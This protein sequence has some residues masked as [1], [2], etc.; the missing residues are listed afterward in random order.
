VIVTV[1]AVRVMQMSVNK[2]VDMVAMRNRLVAASRTVNVIGIMAATGVTRSA[3]SGVCLSDLQCMFLDRPVRVHVVQVAVVQ[4]IDMA[5][6]LDR[7]VTTVGA[8]LVVVV[9]MNMCHRFVPRSKGLR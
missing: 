1:I 9:F 4:V 5:T 6:M 7:G 3:G 2:I 8:V